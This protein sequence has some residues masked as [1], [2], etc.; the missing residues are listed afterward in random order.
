MSWLFARLSWLLA[1]WK[2]LSD[3]QVQI[4][5]MADMQVQVIRLEERVARLEQDNND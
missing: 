2:A 1:P 5:R 3:M 4:M